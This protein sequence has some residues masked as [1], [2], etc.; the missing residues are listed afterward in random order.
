MWADKVQPYPVG[1]TASAAKT[2]PG[3]ALVAPMASL[4]SKLRSLDVYRDTA[5]TLVLMLYQASLSA[6]FAFAATFV[7]SL[8]LLVSGQSV[9]KQSSA[10]FIAGISGTSAVFHL[11]AVFAAFSGLLARHRWRQRPEQP[12][13]PWFWPWRLLRRSA[14]FTVTTVLLI[15]AFAYLVSIGPKA[16]HPF[17]LHF[18]G[19]ICLS[20]FNTA[21][22]DVCTRE[23]YE[24]ETVNGARHASSS[25][26]TSTSNSTLSLRSRDMK[27]SF[28][29][30]VG[31]AYV[32]NVGMIVALSA[33]AAYI[34]VA[35]RVVIKNDWELVAFSLGSLAFRMLILKASQ[36]LTLHHG[37]VHERTIYLSTAVPTVLI[38]TQ[39][40]FI[41]LRVQDRVSINGLVAVMAVEPALR[42]T[43]CALV[44]RRL[45]RLRNRKSQSANRVAV[46][47]V[48]QQVDRVLRFAA[49]EV[50]ADMCSEYI[51]MACSASIFYFFHGHPKFMWR[52]S[53]RDD[54]TV[55]VSAARSTPRYTRVSVFLFQVGLEIL[56]DCVCS[57]WELLLDIPLRVAASVKSHSTI[58]FVAC[59]VANVSVC[60]SLYAAH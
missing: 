4:W 28:W 57:V 6:F 2:S 36:R 1:T 18:Y 52:E 46:T 26:S 5:V 30:R 17:Q 59:A 19:A 51:A 32:R 41:Q 39:V 44:A 21:V 22:V 45:R 54:D 34:Q 25:T 53:P 35:S 16:L 31:R 8:G 48:T 38:D 49:A 37:K 3:P 10:V 33:A 43:R 60:C 20:S 50:H 13:P 14:W 29:R 56:I 24:S 40:R 7:L 47:G 58:L 11:L 12:M 23:L 27:Q 55:T 15:H 9:E 42:L